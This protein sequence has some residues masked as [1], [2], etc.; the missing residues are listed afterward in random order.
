[1]DKKNTMLLT[2]I[3]VAT[4]LVAVVGATFAYF[5]VSA[6][7]T[8]ATTSVVTKVEAVGTVAVADGSD[9]KLD[10]T[11]AQMSE[12]LKGAATYYATA[13]GTPVASEPAATTVAT[14]TA[15]AIADEDVTYSCT[16]N[17][18]VT[19]DATEKQAAVLNATGAS[20][21]KLSTNGTFTL[22]EDEYTLAG[23]ST[24]GTGTLTI[25]DGGTA[26][27]GAVAF[28]KNTNDPQNDLAGAT[29]TTT[30]E[31]TGFACKTTTAQ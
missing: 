15:A 28:L 11:A 23:N 2:V 18:K 19:S 25:T 27:I 20:S 17:Y 1:M 26:T 5:T 3:A 29:I 9:L 24:T 14:F 8:T 21:Y 6:D 10:I 22:S 16:F 12:T 4:L 31:V 30:F 13:S 7:S